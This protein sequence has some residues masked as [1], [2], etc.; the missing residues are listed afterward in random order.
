[1]LFEL[2]KKLFPKIYQA[3]FNSGVSHGVIKERTRYLDDRQKIHLIAQEQWIDKKVIIISNEWED[4]FVGTVVGLEDFE[5][6]EAHLIVRD[7]V[8]KKEFISF[9]K[10]VPFDVANLSALVGMSPWVRWEI[11][12]GQ[13]LDKSVPE[14]SCL[15]TFNQFMDELLQSGFLD[16]QKGPLFEFYEEMVKSNKFISI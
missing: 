15:K 16:E 13:K 2:I 12:T 9:G 7:A 3:I 14:N 4:P 5:R 6:N 1:M 11:L 8:S 10:V